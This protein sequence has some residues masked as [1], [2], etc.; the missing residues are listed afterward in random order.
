MRKIIL[1]LLVT[2]TSLSACKQEPDFDQ[3]FAQTREKID[4]RAAAI[5]RELDIAA[6]DAAAA[7]ADA[8]EESQPTKTAP[9]A[10]AKP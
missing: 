3:R 10:N 1:P 7:H 9:R 5:D 2:L 6:S 8:P 4:A